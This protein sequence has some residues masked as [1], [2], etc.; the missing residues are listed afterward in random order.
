MRAK[1][2]L[3]IIFSCFAFK[4]VA[5]TTIPMSCGTQ[6]YAN[7]VPQNDVS[8]A[9]QQC[10]NTG[11]TSVPIDTLGCSG[12]SKGLSCRNNCT[13]PSGYSPLVTSSGTV[14]TETCPAPNVSFD[15]VCQV[16]VESPQECESPTINVTAYQMPSG[17]YVCM[18]GA[19]YPCG[20]GMT[21]GTVAGSNSIISVCDQPTGGSSSSSSSE[22]STSSSAGSSDGGGGSSDGSG[23]EGSSSTGSSAS[24]SSSSSSSSGGGG[25]S[26]SSSGGGSGSSEGDGGCENCNEGSGFDLDGPS[27]GEAFQDFSDGVSNTPVVSSIGNFLTIPAG[28]GCPTWTVTAWVFDITIDQFCSSSIPWGLISGMILF[29]A[30]VLAFRIAF[31]NGS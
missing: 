13:C 18:P 27:V 11:R 31:T 26:S 20:E 8:I 19:D 25:G 21:P 14:C 9:I 12:T 17:G 7:C 15:G 23:G 29:V 2:L 3:L 22:S 10:A 6:A 1:I 4:S 16:P 28:G 5:Q 30:S 24:S